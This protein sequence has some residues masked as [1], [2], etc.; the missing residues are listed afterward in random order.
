MRRSWALMGV[1]TTD[2]RTARWFPSWVGNCRCVDQSRPRLWSYG[3]W[4]QAEDPP[5]RRA[6]RRR[7][8]GQRP[9]LHVVQR[10]EPGQDPEPAARRCGVRP[11][12][13][14]DR[15]GRPGLHA[16]GQRPQLPRARPLRPRRRPRPLLGHGARPL[17]PGPRGHRHGAQAGRGLRRRA[18]L[19]RHEVPLEVHRGQ[20]QD[21]VGLGSGPM[22]TL[23]RAC[24]ILAL[25]ACAYGIGASLYGA[26]T[27]RREWA[28]SGRRAFYALAGLLTISFGVLEL[29]FLRS[30]FSFATVASHSSTTTPGFYKA[31]AAWSSQEGSLMLWLWLLSMWSSLVL[32]LTRRGLR[33]IA[34]YAT[35][36]LLGF[37][38]F[39]SAL[40]VF[41]ETPFGLPAGVAEGN[42]LNPLLRHRA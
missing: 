11:L 18:R 30:D 31:A 42:G 1:S 21:Q 38:A 14:A 22:P 36:V 9:D 3:P 35:A 41:L 26:R 24:L 28:E 2:A 27:G 15:Q 39:F 40:L 23:G 25:V 12:L 19:A 16:R 4:P 7:A 6:D 37:A 32:F 13:P 33:R 34:P 10:L 8:P 29:A 17:P 20:D 5:R